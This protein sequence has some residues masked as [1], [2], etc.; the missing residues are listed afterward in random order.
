MEASAPYP[1]P[2]DGRL[3][4]ARL[5]LLA[6]GCQGWW[7]ERTEESRN[8]L[9][10]IN[11]LA[12]VMRLQGGLVVFTRIAGVA[13]ANGR[14]ARGPEVGG[15]GWELLLRPEPGDFVVDTPGLNAFFASS[16]DHLL[17]SCRRDRLAI[18]GLGLETVLYSTVTGANDRG[19]EC[20]ILSDAA[21]AHDKPVAQRALNSITMSGGIFGAIGSTGALSAALSS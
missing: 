20:L 13:G 17:R 1:W 12:G 7:A 18:G 4:P 5:A 11:T 14:P 8:V 16:L 15:P 3:E 9:R 2:F 19:Y 6:V 21:A 10:A